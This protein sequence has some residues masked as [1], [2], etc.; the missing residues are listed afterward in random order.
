ME[1]IKSQ[2]PPLA[3]KYKLPSYEE[4]D[5]EFELLYIREVCEIARPL[6]FIRR[7]I[8]DKIG[9]VC[10]MLQALLQPNPSSLVNMKEA[11]FLTREEK[12]QCQKLLKELMS[13]ERYSLSLDVETSEQNDAEYIKTGI[14]S[15]KAAKPIIRAITQ[16]LHQGWKQETKREKNIQNY[17][18]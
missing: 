4:L 10:N 11:S 17:T 3:Q 18:G 13:L 5:Q 16:H 12:E 8:N 2:Y 14:T 9:W 15:W 6:S 7:R 1:Q